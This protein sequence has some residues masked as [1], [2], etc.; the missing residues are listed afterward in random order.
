MSCGLH[1]LR[2]ELS[3]LAF[4]V[5]SALLFAVR[6]ASLPLVHSVFPPVYWSRWALCCHR[7]WPS[8]KHFRR[9]SA[10]LLQ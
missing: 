3:V 9:F 4:A 1:R 8:S 2:F 6:S 10:D 5:Y 7:F